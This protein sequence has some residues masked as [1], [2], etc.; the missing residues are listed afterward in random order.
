MKAEFDKIKA[1]LF[2]GRGYTYIDMYVVNFYLPLTAVKNNLIIKNNKCELAARVSMIF[3]VGRLIDE[4][5]TFRVA[6][7]SL[8]P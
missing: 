5:H 4:K 7:G 6:A 2:L 1:N 3:I 8:Y